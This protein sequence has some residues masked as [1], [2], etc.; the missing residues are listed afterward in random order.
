VEEIDVV[1]DPADSDQRPDR[2]CSVYVLR[3]EQARLRRHRP[4]PQQSA[5]CGT[6]EERDGKRPQEVELLFERE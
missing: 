5:H 4:R 3:G 6:S 2:Q 1:S